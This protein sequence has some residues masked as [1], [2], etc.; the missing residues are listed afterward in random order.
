MKKLLTLLMAIVLSFSCVTGLV[1]CNRQGG[2]DFDNTKSHLYVGVYNAG[3]GVEWLKDI[4][5]RFEDFY[6]E[7]EFEAG[8]KGIQ[9]HISDIDAGN[10]FISQIEH[11]PQEVI[12]TSNANY[13]QF[14]REGYV[15]KMTDVVTKPATEFGET[16]SLEQRMYPSLINFLKFGDD[17]YGLTYTEGSTGF[18]MNVDLWESK[19]LYF[20]KGG[21]P[22]EYCEFTKTNNADAVEGEWSEDKLSFTGKGEKSAGPDGKYGTYD[23]GQPATYD[24][25]YLFAEHCA[26]SN[27]QTFHISGKWPQTISKIMIPMVANNEREEQM[28][29]NFNYN[30]VAKNLISVDAEGN[31]TELDDVTIT[32]RNGYLLA[33]QKGKYQALKFFETLLDNHNYYNFQTSMNNLAHTHTDAQDDFVSGG[34]I[35]GKK[36]I[37]LLLDGEWWFNEA[38]PA[39]NVLETSKGVQHGAANRRFQMM[40]YPKATIDQVGEKEIIYTAEPSVCMINKSIADIKVEW[41]EK[42]VQFA[43]T[44]ESC[45][46]FTTFT[47]AVQPYTCEYPEG[48]LDSLHYYSKS[49][50]ERHAN[51]E[52]VFGSDKGDMYIYNAMDFYNSEMFWTS[53]MNGKNQSVP[54]TSM[55]KEGVSA[56][57]YFNGMQAYRT[58][59]LWNSLYSQYFGN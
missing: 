1:G 41:A 47:N 24:E 51:S 15:R 20:E 46:R 40:A 56:E 36:N 54:A 33:K 39:F 14:I 53:T 12:F 27:V 28:L 49:I 8:K 16:K 13:H 23:D 44:N 6:K 21:C 11:S 22:S 30:G 25:F 18:V 57:T 5:I 32:P 31:V 42:F 45:L 17:Y 34:I 37:A 4:K 38:K 7:K 48:Y 9:V 43:F 55:G 3:Y 29:L 2:E 35:T 58:E 50:V 10:L 52:K 19:S 59:T 26:E